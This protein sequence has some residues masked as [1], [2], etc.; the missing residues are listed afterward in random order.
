MKSVYLAAAFAAN[1]TSGSEVRWLSEVA[2]W[3][4]QMDVSVVHFA[5]LQET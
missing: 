2:V 1:R 4:E 5:F 3:I